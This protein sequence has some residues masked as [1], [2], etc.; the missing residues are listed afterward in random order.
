MDESVTE[1]VELVEGLCGPGQ[2]SKPEAVEFLE[3]VIERL[4]TSIEALRD[5]IANEEES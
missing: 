3:E 1:A 4:R 5:E 2:M